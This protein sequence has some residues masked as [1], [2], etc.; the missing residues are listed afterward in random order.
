MLKGLF[1]RS[2]NAQRR[3]EFPGWPRYADAGKAAPRRPG[4]RKP[5]CR[6]CASS[7]G[8][9]NGGPNFGTSIFV[10]DNGRWLMV[11]HQAALIPKQR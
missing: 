8:E 7:R 11:F 1:R 5:A 3:Q 4:G 9:T 10:K 2:S 6:H